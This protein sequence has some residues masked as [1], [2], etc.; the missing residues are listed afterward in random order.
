MSASPLAG[1]LVVDLSRYL[2]GPYASRLLADLGARVLKV[3]EPELGDPVRQAPPRRAGSSALGALLLHGQASVALD[4]KREDGRAVLLGLLERADVLLETLRPGT[5]ARLGL[6]PRALRA[7][8]PRLILCSLSGF[9]QDGPLARRAGHDLTYQALG[10]L[11]APTGTMPSLP[12]ADI[13]GAW[14]AA[15]AILA[16]LYAREKSGDGAWTDAAMLDAAAH[17]NVTSWAVEAGV[18]QPAGRRLPLTGALSCYNLYR[19]KGGELIAFAPLEPKHWRTFCDAVSRPRW[20]NRQ[21]DRSPALRRAVGEV[22]AQ[23]T[24]EEWTA[25]FA[26]HDFPGA[27]VLAAAEAAAS[28]QMEARGV[29]ERGPEG[30]PR[31]RFPARFDGERPRGA[32][33]RP[34]G[35][36]ELPALGA[37]TRAVLEEWGRPEA[38]RSDRALRRRGIGPRWSLRRWLWRLLSR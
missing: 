18:A 16:A 23:R 34:R 7:R 4:L 13:L 38:A 22:L 33:E 32:D 12:A 28:P 3:E 8:F 37:D 10:G 31:L 11:L 35:A 14:A 2:P 26:E 20:R 30:L 27:P 21:Y 19:A 29:L 9:G 17:G 5:L 6:D 15:S 24:R 25:W 1:V 36:D